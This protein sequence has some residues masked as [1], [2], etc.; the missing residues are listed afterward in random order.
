[1]SNAHN[2]M[3]LRTVDPAAVRK[4]FTPDASSRP[5][6][7]HRERRRLLKAGL[8]VGARP[9]ALTASTAAELGACIATL[10]LDAGRQD[11]LPG[12]EDGTTDLSSISGSLRAVERMD[13]A[14][15]VGWWSDLVD[16]AE[17]NMIGDPSVAR[18]SGGT[19]IGMRSVVGTLSSRLA[20][21]AESST[22]T[23]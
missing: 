4:A 18:M 8:W 3:V 6:E 19:V 12:I 1:M 7:S 10:V 11:V 9:K 15:M 13:D 2:D 21:V 5:L 14:G 16:A 20:A 22:P 17:D 23:R